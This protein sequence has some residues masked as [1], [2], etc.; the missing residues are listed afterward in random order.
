VLAR[1]TFASL[2]VGC[3]LEAATRALVLH[4]FALIGTE[5]ITIQ[6]PTLFVT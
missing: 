3:V 1:S 2:A 6:G 5:E 4:V